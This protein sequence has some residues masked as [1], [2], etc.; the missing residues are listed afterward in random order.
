MTS[1][2]IPCSCAYSYCSV[3]LGAGVQTN[4]ALMFAA[5]NSATTSMRSFNRPPPPLEQTSTTAPVSLLSNEV[6]RQIFSRATLKPTAP[7]ELDT[8]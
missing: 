4:S 2:L 1:H 8:K 5:H 7:G 6:R 3:R